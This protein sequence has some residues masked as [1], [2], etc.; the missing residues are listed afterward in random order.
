MIEGCNKNRQGSKKEMG[1]RKNEEDN[2]NA[3]TD[4]F[5]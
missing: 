3:S 5:R 4:I 2:E 1:I